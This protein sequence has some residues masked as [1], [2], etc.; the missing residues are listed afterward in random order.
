MSNHS[1]STPL[2][3]LTLHNTLSG[4]LEPFSPQDPHEVKIYCCG[5]TVYSFQHIGNFKTFLF[6]DLLIR[7]LRFFGYGV[8]HVMNITDVGH[9]TDDADSGEDKMLIAMRRE[10]KTSA[11][12]AAF[13]TKRFFADWDALNL[14]RPSVVCKATEH[15]TEMISLIERLQKAGYAYVAGGNVYF[16]VEK[17]TTYGALGRL[18]L[19]GMRAGARITVDPHKRSPFDFALWFT[20]SKFENQELTWDSPWGRGYP[21]WHIECSA[22][23]ICHLGE[24]IDIHCGGI[25]HIPVHH[26]NE[27]AQ[28]EAAIG[29]RW[30]STWLHGEFMQINAE[31]MSKSI[32]NLICLSDL[33]ERGI[34]PLAFRYLCLMSHYRSQLNFTWE[35]VENAQAAYTKLCRTV[36]NLK[37]A[38]EEEKSGTTTP[39]DSSSSELPPE[40]GE[41]LCS[42][43]NTPKAMAVLMAVLKDN[44]RS[45]TE[46]LAVLSRADLVLGLRFDELK[47]P[48]TSE[49]PEQVK[50]LLD[51]RAAARASKDWKGSDALRDEL[52]I[53][54]YRVKDTPNGQEIEPITG[55]G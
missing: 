10:G 45:A 14:F 54:G 25:D 12:I 2:T 32:G 46:R 50:H 35:A 47:A 15:I 21:G 7:T 24:Q 9:L 4:R 30:V 52:L 49:L 36:L 43:L 8:K 16:D 39:I 18:D 1:N 26:T 27:I 5:P 40:F 51:Q 19:E 28:S 38:A 17:F 6:E 42:D 37:A 29:H 41:A 31:K 53:L 55:A 44:T 13:Y 48:S 22:M 11:E 33:A 20:R 23:G 3:T 34:S